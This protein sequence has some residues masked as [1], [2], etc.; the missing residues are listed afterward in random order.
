MAAN[1]FR[2]LADASNSG[3]GI[4][5]KPSEVWMLLELTGDAIPLAGDK[6][7]E[8]CEFFEEYEVMK[9]LDDNKA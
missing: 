5:L 6:L 3:S 4:S 8:R 7:E 9:R 2:Q 1:V